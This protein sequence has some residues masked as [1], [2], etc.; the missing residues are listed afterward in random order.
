MKYNFILSHRIKIIFA[1]STIA[2][3]VFFGSLGPSAAQLIDGSFTGFFGSDS[4]KANTSFTQALES[5]KIGDR[6][7]KN[8]QAI[9]V[10]YSGRDHRPYWATRKGPQ[11][12]AYDFLGALESSWQ[13]GLNP[14]AYE[15]N[16]IRAMAQESGRTDFS[17]LELLLT[18]SFLRYYHD[19]SGMRIDP[20]RIGVDGRGWRHSVAPEEA[21]E[22]LG[23][24]EKMAEILSGL[25][26]KSTTYKMLQEELVRLIQGPP[27]PYLHVMPL[28][29]SDQILRPGQRHARIPDLRIRLGVTPQTDDD[30]LYDDKLAA[31]VMQFQRDYSLADDGL[32]GKNTLET[33]NIT[34]QDRIHQVIANMERIRWLG[35]ERP[36]KYVVVNIPSATLWAIESDRVELEMPVIVGKPE[37]ATPSFITQITGVRFN[38]DWTVP[39]TIK[40]D[41][42]WPKLKADP[43]YLYNKG[44]E[45][46]WEGQT[47]DPYAVE[48]NNLIP[49]DLHQLTMVQIPGNHNPLGRVRVL[50]PNKYDVYLHDTNDR[51]HFK[52]MKR[53]LSSGCIRMESPRDMAAFIMRSEKGWDEN[54]VATALQDYKTR[55]YL[56]SNPVPVYLMYYTVWVD[57]G[58]RLVYGHDLYG[59][60]QKLIS[61]LMEVDGIFIPGHN[62]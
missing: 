40:R 47:L 21:A 42:I 12:H 37:R 2:S 23:F 48:W 61:A 3:T 59:Q 24:G 31:S 43:E 62:I 19:M 28:S 32:I 35:A 33:L 30:L 25:T 13:H 29:F 54:R 51:R 27:E 57:E 6:N 14:E 56:I 8:H 22:V 38:P 1:I 39:P 44:I 53:A 26:P 46:Y 50:M 10:F 15:I 41:D 34:R 16:R 17:E 52:T 45:L 49:N 7:L 4:L 36:D 55:D 60:D 9:A 5:G 18:E 58:G 20:Q 11:K